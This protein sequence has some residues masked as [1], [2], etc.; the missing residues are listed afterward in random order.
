M[1]ILVLNP[2]GATQYNGP[3]VLFENLFSE[4]GRLHVVTLITRGQARNSSRDKWLFNTIILGK[5]SKLSILQQVAWAGRAGLYLLV[6]GGKHDLVHLHGVYLFNL[7]PAIAALLRGIPCVALPLCA[8]GDLS[9]AARSNRGLIMP[10]L[11][12]ALI[13]RLA[14][15]YALAPQIHEELAGLGLERKRIVSLPTIVDSRRFSPPTRSLPDPRG[16]LHVLGS[17]GKVGERKGASVVLNALARVRECGW[18]DASALFV[19]PFEDAESEI[20]FQSLVRKLGLVGAVT[21]TG[22]VLDVE[23][24]MNNRIGLFALPS[25]QEGLPSALAEAMS[26]GLPCAVTDVGSMGRVVGDSGCGVVIPPAGEQQLAQFALALWEN[27]ERWQQHST[28]ARTY[29]RKHFEAT[30]VADTYLSAIAHSIAPEF[31]GETGR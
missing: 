4:V 21:V 18:V 3:F 29:A 26:S 30:G 28:A 27:Q 23:S 13:S 6:R 19:G 8:A 7:L 16:L 24:Y 5:N 31:Q 9:G 14:V 15:G 17:V 22:Y 1:K 10:V 11:R 2:Y 12:R 25:R 20:A